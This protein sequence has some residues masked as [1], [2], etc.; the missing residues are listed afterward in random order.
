MGDIKMKKILVIVIL[1]MFLLASA[2]S[3]SAI[4]INNNNL[5]TLNISGNTIYVDDDNT[6]GPWDGTAEHPF[7]N[8]Q[9]GINH[10]SEGDIVYVF[11]GR[12][13]EAIAISKSI[14]LQG[15]DKETTFIEAWASNTIT[16]TAKNVQISGFNI[17]GKKYYQ[18]AIYINENGQALVTDNILKLEDFGS[19]IKLSY[20]KNNIITNNEFIGN[21]A[22]GVLLLNSNYNTIEKNICENIKWGICGENSNYNFFSNNQ[23]NSLEEGIDLIFGCSNN[24]IVEND[25]INCDRGVNVGC[26]GNKIHHNNFYSSNPYDWSGENI[27][28]CE[29]NLGNYYSN[30]NGVDN[31]Q[32]FIGDTAY[33]IKGCGEVK[34]NYP[35]MSAYGKP[36]APIISGPTEG[37]INEPH[38]YTFRSVDYDGDQIYYFVTW[39]NVNSGWMGPYDSGVEKLIK[40][41]WE[42][43]GFYTIKAK[44]K[45]ENG[46]EGEWTYYRVRM[47]REK[48]LKTNSFLLKILN[49]FPILKQILNL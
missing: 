46:N 41:I 31:N 22:H 15:S 14:T 49:Q 34:D 6:Q 43:E 5:E 12:Y 36:S 42:K 47:P 37:A 7:Q 20:S 8:I 40:N 38:E 45:D 27:W 48:G 3:V 29:N 16:V 23:L 19:E 10:A 1:S 28:N 21:P 44:A 18:D 4:Q 13:N 39:G 33:S 9:D 2:I 32:D 11:N 30:Y 24:E 35:L 26:S 25:F 17:I